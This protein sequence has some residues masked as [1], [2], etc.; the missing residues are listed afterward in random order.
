L[1]LAPGIWLLGLREGGAGE[2]HDQKQ[3]S[4]QNRADIHLQSY[5][6]VSKTA[7]LDEDKS[8]FRA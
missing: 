8:R 1:G 7:E 6:P 2:G 4:R 5:S 3:N